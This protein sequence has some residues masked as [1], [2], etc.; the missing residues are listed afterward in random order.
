VDSSD[1]TDGYYAVDKQNDDK[2]YRVIRHRGI[3]I[4][5]SPIFDKKHAVG[6][7]GSNSRIKVE[8]VVHYKGIT[9]LY[10]GHGRYITANETWVNKE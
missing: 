3:V 4:Y 5:N 6:K 2:Y 8:K 10:I 7:I 9:R 1:Y